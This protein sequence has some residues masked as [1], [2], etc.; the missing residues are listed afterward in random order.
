MQSCAYAYIIFYAHAWVCVVPKTIHTSPPQKRFFLR[1]PR[2]TPPPPPLW[3]FQSSFI[4]LV[5]T[6][7]W[8]FE[9]THPPPQEFSIPSVGGVWIFSGTTQ[10]WSQLNESWIGTGYTFTISLDKCYCNHCI[11]Q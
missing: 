10:F 1:P 3:K 5:N 4:H 6:C 8:A 2:P 11:T 9:N 7:I